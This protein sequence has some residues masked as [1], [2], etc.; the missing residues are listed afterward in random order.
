MNWDTIAKAAQ[1]SADTG[2]SYQRG[3]ELAL[4]QE[5]KMR[6][7]QSGMMELA[8]KDAFYEDRQAQMGL[9]L[10]SKMPVLNQAL[11]DQEAR[12]A[13]SPF[14]RIE[15]VKPITELGLQTIPVPEAVVP[16]IDT[17]SVGP[18]AKKIKE[19]FQS[20]VNPYPNPPGVN[21]RPTPTPTL[22]PKGQRKPQGD[23]VQP[24]EDQLDLEEVAPINA[25]L[26]ETAAPMSPFTA[27]RSPEFRRQMF[28]AMARTG[29]I[30]GLAVQSEKTFDALKGIRDAGFM[31]AK[32]SASLNQNAQEINAKL[33]MQRLEAQMKNAEFQMQLAQKAGDQNAERLYKTQMEMFKGMLDVL[34]SQT[35]PAP[36][37]S[38]KEDPN[39]ADYRRQ[40]N[41]FQQRASGLEAE[42]VKKFRVMS[43]QNVQRL[44]RT[45]PQTWGPIVQEGQRLYELGAKYPSIRANYA[46]FSNLIG[47]AGKV[48]GAQ[49]KTESLA[50]RARRAREAKEKAAGSPRG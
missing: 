25:A 27:L 47:P 33:E 46:G 13:L 16:G 18:A 21:A 22:P 23:I 4:A 36:R 14:G 1:V 2:L 24:L 7:A 31:A 50:D 3:L 6:A 17:G 8:L 11:I 15:S 49:L 20:G 37:G 43:P 34:S 28:D 44:V 38:S 35:R 19:G 12:A 41:Q 9:D 30:P 32:S 45:N 40:L 39:A 26:E 5:E 10:L 42:V 29:S 48:G